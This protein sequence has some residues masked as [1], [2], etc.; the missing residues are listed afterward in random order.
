LGSRSASTIDWAFVGRTLLDLLRRALLPAWFLLFGLRMAQIYIGENQLGCDFRIYHRD[1]EL[2][3][4]GGDPWSAGA[5]IGGPAH[6]AA[7]PSEL[8]PLIPLAPLG[9]DA[10]GVVWLV[11]CVL[12]AVFVV[13]RL[14]L[15]R[16]VAPLSAYAGQLWYRSIDE[17]A[18]RSRLRELHGFGRRP[19]R[20][21]PLPEPGTRP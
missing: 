1:L 6:F 16:G 12:A 20:P 9:E 15:P 14:R 5:D 11:V 10:A 18:F 4:S 8:F 19:A 17:A 7:P 13:R 2:W 3:L 21:E